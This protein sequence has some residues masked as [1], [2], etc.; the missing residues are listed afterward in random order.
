MYVWY[1]TW[2][3]ENGDGIEDTCTA[4]RIS[5]LDNFLNYKGT[6]IRISSNSSNNGIRFFTDV[7]AVVQTALTNGTLLSG[8]LE[9]YK[10]VE[11]G[12]LYKWAASGT[13]LTVDNGAISYVYGG[14]AGEKF[15][16]FSK[17]GSYNRFTGMLVGLD[18]DAKTLTADIVS[19]PFAVLENASGDQITLYGGSIQRSIYYVALQN[20]D[21]WDEGTAYDKYIESIIAKV[22]GT[23]G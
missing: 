20:R 2:T 14:D 13:D 23:A 21:Y 15:R 10:L 1:L 16:L 7:P 11:M 9:G 12:T 22:E 6:S 8:M 3:D 19:R 4:K 17:E 18:G 5:Q